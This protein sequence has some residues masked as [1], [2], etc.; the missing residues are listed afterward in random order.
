MKYIFGAIQ[1]TKFDRR[2]R[3]PCMTEFQ[4][5]EAAANFAQSPKKIKRKKWKLCAFPSLNGL[6][7]SN[8]HLF[9]YSAVVIGKNTTYK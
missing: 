6:F 1:T 9:L 2:K 5:L 3:L 7:L 4:S 8:D